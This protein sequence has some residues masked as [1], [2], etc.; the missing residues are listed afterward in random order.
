RRR[1]RHVGSSGAAAAEG[2]DHRPVGSGS[3]VSRRRSAGIAVQAG[4]D[5]RAARR[6]ARPAGPARPQAGDVRHPSAAAPRPQPERAA[7]DRRN[8]A[9]RRRRAVLLGRPGRHR[10]KSPMSETGV[11][12]GWDPLW[13]ATVLLVVTYGVIMTER[14][15]RAIVALIGAGLMILTG[16]I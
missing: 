13:V 1:L 16:V 11:W 6:P 8:H 5:R 9:A 3:R 7:S 14:I 12:F 15:N 10:Q 4:R 2:G